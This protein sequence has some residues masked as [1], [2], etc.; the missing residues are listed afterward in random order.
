MTGSEVRQSFLDYFARHGHEVVPS[1]SLVP[2][3]DLLIDTE[4][5]TLVGGLDKEPVEDVH[6]AVAG[7]A[8]DRLIRGQGFAIGQNLLR[9]H[10]ERLRTLGRPFVFS[11]RMAGGLL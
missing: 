7:G 10:I 5:R 3:D 8:G 2:A 11:Q 1:S 9:R 4:D 6:E